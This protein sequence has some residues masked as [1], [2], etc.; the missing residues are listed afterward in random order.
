MKILYYL[1]AVLFCFELG[2]VPIYTPDQPERS[3][4]IIKAPSGWAYRT[5]KGENG[6][7][8]VLWPKQTSFNDCETAVFV[9][10]Q[11]FNEVFLPEFPDNIQLFREKC[12]KA[13]FKF[14]T[15][16]EDN[17]PTLS[18]EEKYFSGFCG[19]TEVVFE[20]KVKNFRIITVLASSFYVSDELFSDVREIVAAYKNEVQNLFKKQNKQKTEPIMNNEPLEVIQQPQQPQPQLQLRSTPQNRIPPAPRQLQ[21]RQAPPMSSPK[22]SRRQLL[23]RN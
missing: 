4:F 8:G 2:S 12:P 22:M 3:R 19:R 17:D 16:E 5:F 1:F 18:I 14:A 15:L 20:E 6:L 13:D 23:R 11:D 10:L 21:P 7:I 9:F